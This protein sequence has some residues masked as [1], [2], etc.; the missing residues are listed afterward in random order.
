M[1][2]RSVH[3]HVRHLIHLTS[4]QCST[5]GNLQM[6]LCRKEEIPRM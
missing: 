6:V 3:C 1:V 2:N 4:G 5:K